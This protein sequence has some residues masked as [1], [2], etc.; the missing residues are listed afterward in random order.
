MQICYNFYV[1]KAE[2][3]GLKVYDIDFFT[4]AFNIWLT[5]DSSAVNVAT[6]HYDNLFTVQTLIFNNKEIKYN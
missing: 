1:E 6:T 2:Q 5:F 4:K 3:K